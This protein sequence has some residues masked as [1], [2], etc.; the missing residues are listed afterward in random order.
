MLVSIGVL[1]VVEPSLVKLIETDLPIK[2]SYQ[3]SK[4]FDTINGE[5]RKAEE[6]R[7]ALVRKYGTQHDDGL[8]VE[9]DN[10]AAFMAD[11]NEL[12]GIQI[13]LNTEPI[14]VKA[15]LDHNERLEKMGHTPISLNAFDISNLKQLGVLTDVEEAPEPKSE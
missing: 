7:V 10:M 11:Y 5:L 14:Q 1:K 6:H 9:E 13:E 3:L 15:L 12:M 2:M 4:L 8:K